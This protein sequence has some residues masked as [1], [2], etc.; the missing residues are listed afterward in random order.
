MPTIR[1]SNTFHGSR[2]NRQPYA[3]R[4]STSSTTKIASM[5]WSTACSRPPTLAISEE[6]VSRPSV[7]A[8][9]TI[10]QMMNCWNRLCSTSSRTRDLT[11]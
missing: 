10:T 4:R 7:I 9:A 3:Y 2:K 5:T 1:K 6:D 8:F 11:S